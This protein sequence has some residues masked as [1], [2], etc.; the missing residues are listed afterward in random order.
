MFGI[1]GFEALLSL[2]FLLIIFL[3]CR[4]LICWYWKLNSIDTTLK[5]IADRLDRMDGATPTK[6]R[7]QD[8]SE[9]P[10]KAI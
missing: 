8:V 4:E 6:A 3:V 7:R 2:A 10:V 5:R 9:D 1:G